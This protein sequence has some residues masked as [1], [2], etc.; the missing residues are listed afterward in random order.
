[1]NGEAVKA[2]I[3]SNRALAQRLA[4]NG[5]PS[6]VFESEMLRGYVPI[7]GMREVI[8]QIRSN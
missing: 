3:D 6:F 7:D 5:T 4:I 8:A 2:I 1:M